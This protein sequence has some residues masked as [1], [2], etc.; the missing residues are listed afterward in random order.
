MTTR[1]YRRENYLGN[2]NP[3]SGF[4]LKAI[5]YEKCLFTGSAFSFVEHP[6][7][8][9]LIQ[10]VRLVNCEARSC[11]LYKA[12]IEDCLV[13]DLR[14]RG[15]VHT[16]A[17]AFKRVTLRGRIGALMISSAV[18]GGEV[19]NDVQ[20]AFDEANAIYYRDVDWAL[21]I[22]EAEMME[23]DIRNVPAKLVRRD[24]KTQVVI[25][26]Q[27]ALEGVW[28]GLDLS[29]TYWPL[30][31]QFFLDRGDDDVVLAAPKRHPNYERLL[32][33]LR[34]L[35]DAGVAEPE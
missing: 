34:M 5:D 18:R 3:A 13:S 15:N 31:I 28:R 26:K 10:G 32:D 27:K 30:A 6:R 21:D 17:V 12:C 14:T 29:S 4:L 8:R 24:P 19:D 7:D 25:K 35:R 22:S 20:R 11:S 2:Y 1:S 9:P 16:W 23:V 33:G